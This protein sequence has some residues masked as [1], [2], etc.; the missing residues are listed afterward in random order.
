MTRTGDGS[1]RSWDE[2]AAPPGEPRKSVGV[3]QGSAAERYVEVRY[4]DTVDVKKY[5][6][7]TSVMG[8][9]ERG[10]LD[11]LVQDVPIGIHYS[12]DFPGLHSVGKPQAPGYYVA[13][14]RQGDDR[15]LAALNVAI[16]SAIDDGTLER[17]YRK[18]GIWNDDQTRPRCRRAGP[19]CPTTRSCCSGLL[20]PRFSSRCCRCRWRSCSD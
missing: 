9:V 19:T 13:Y 4:G 16:Q 14:V 3:L 5:P 12:P 20:G 17:L 15:F 11:A 6:E 7:L 8:L 10:Q 18:Y 1:I 2:L